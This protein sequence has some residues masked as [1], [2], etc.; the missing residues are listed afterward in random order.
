MPH[1][2]RH[3]G[4]EALHREMSC[5][6]QSSL[7]R[8]VFPLVCPLPC[9]RCEQQLN[10]KSVAPGVRTCSHAPSLL[11]GS[12]LRTRS[13]NTV[14]CTVDVAVRCSL[15]RTL[16]MSFPSLRRQRELMIASKA[17]ID[18]NRKSMASESSCN[19]LKTL[20][21]NHNTISCSSHKSS[22]GSVLA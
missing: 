10:P 12:L 2:L 17:T 20:W 14:R 11:E 3:S 8:N 9:C 22:C 5:L 1:R 18:S 7:P 13:S 4:A 16:P 6:F 21:Q 15:A 19:L